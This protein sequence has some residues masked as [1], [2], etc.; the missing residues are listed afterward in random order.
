MNWYVLLQEQFYLC[1]VRLTHYD[2]WKED[3]QSSKCNRSIIK[4]LVYNRI[5]TKGIAIAGQRRA[6]ITMRRP[7]YSGFVKFGATPDGAG[8]APVIT[9]ALIAKCGTISGI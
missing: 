1:V 8:Q 2:Y 5:A 7:M 3:L 9:A 6:T 4:R